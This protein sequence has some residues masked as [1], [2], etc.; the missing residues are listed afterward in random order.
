M[1]HTFLLLSIIILNYYSVLNVLNIL[2]IAF[3]YFCGKI[4]MS[5]KTITQHKTLQFF[6]RTQ[7]SIYFA[8]SFLYTIILLQYASF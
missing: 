3:Y 6:K 1:Y 8:V 7:Q 2:L 5:E 4:M